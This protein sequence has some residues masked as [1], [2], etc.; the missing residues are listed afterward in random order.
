[1]IIPKKYGGLGFSA[2]FAHSEVVRKLSTRSITA[3]VTAMV[4][5]SLGP[6]ELL[7]MFGTQEQRDLLAAAP[8][9]RARDPLLRPHL[10]RKPAPTPP[11]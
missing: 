3:A 5:N 4:P 8:R 11:R 6:G 9:R 1:M 7:M 2:T 10:A